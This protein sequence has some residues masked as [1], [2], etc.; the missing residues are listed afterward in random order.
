MMYMQTSMWGTWLSVM[1]GGERMEG[2]ALKRFTGCAQ[3]CFL[4][5]MRLQEARW[6]EADI[7]DRAVNKAIL[8]ERQFSKY[9]LS[10]WMTTW[11]SHLLEQSA[12]RG[13]KGN[14]TSVWNAKSK[15]EASKW[16]AENTEG[17]EPSGKTHTH[18]EKAAV[19]H[20]MFR[21][22]FSRLTYFWVGC[23]Q[24]M[25]RC[26]KV[27]LITLAEEHRGKSLGFEEPS[28]MFKPKRFLTTLRIDHLLSTKLFLKIEFSV[29]AKAWLPVTVVVTQSSQIYTEWRWS[30]PVSFVTCSSSI[31]VLHLLDRMFILTLLVCLKPGAMKHTGP[32]HWFAGHW[33]SWYMYP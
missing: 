25:G 33:S 8:T 3:D 15:W 30:K 19:G 14:S 23:F 4:W 29:T 10:S 12:A 2:I 18:T 28:D 26:L 9:L 7:L 22:W 21:G 13:Q 27:T 11:A 1:E 6:R 20:E 17:H 24:V 32:L 31:S 5:C 16:V